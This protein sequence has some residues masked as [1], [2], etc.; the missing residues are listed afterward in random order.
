MS[1]VGAGRL[2]EELG[3]IVRA[4]VSHPGKKGLYG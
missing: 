3:A 2:R 1:R 4:L